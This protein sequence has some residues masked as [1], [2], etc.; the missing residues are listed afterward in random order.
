MSEWY[1]GALA[2]Q[3][4]GRVLE[5]EA[6]KDQLADILLDQ[7]RWQHPD[8]QRLVGRLVE[9]FEG[10]TAFVDDRKIPATNNDTEQD[11]RPIAVMR[12]VTGGTR[13]ANGSRSLAHWMTITQTLHKN[14][15]S[16]RE[17]VIGAYQ[18]HLRGRDPPSVFADR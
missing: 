18:A 8:V 7:P 9:H 14:G 13:S 17:Y 16:V 10:A 1:Q 11:I 4:R 6:A 12:K 5:R 15:L 3:R 2:A